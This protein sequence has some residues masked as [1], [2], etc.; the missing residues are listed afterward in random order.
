LLLPP[1]AAVLRRIMCALGAGW[2]SSTPAELPKVESERAPAR[3]P[4]AVSEQWYGSSE[5]VVAKLSG[6]ARHRVAFAS[7][8]SVCLS[9][10]TPRDTPQKPRGCRRALGSTIDGGILFRWRSGWRRG[11]CC[12]GYHISLKKGPKIAVRKLWRRRPPCDKHW[13]T[14]LVHKGTKLGDR[15][16]VYPIRRALGAENK[17][18]RSPLSHFGNVVKHDV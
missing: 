15:R 11:L 2:R 13:R 8:V 18:R 12:N 16:Y 5:L 7:F 17:G 10:P 9:A 14:D 1:S 4:T 6:E 3:L